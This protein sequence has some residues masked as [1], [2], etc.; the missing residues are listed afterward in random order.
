MTEIQSEGAGVTRA[1][2]ERAFSGIKK[3]EK[4]FF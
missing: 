1:D 3:I 2:G 4:K